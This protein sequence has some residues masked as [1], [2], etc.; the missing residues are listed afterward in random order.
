MLH[1]TFFVFVKQSF[2]GTSFFYFGISPG[3]AI[4]KIEVKKDS[5]CIGIKLNFQR[6]IWKNQF[7]YEVF[8]FQV[9]ENTSD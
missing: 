7:I 1:N 3:V 4:P 2:V 5:F 9:E 8:K 6:L